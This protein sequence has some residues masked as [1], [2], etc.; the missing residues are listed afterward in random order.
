MLLRIDILYG[1]KLLRP[2][3]GV[4]INCS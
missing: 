1:W 2:D 3:W 4:R